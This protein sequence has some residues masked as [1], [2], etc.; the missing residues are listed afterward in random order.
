MDIINKLVEAF[1]MHPG[2]YIQWLT[3]SCRDFTLS[4]TLFYML[5]MH[6][7]QKINSSSGKVLSIVDALTI[8][9]DNQVLSISKHHNFFCL[10]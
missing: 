2:D 7:L 10:I 3:V 6:S 5:L 9:A 8:H 4:K 1:M